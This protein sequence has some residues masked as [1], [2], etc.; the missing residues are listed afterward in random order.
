MPE[1]LSAICSARQGVVA[2]LASHHTEG[3]NAMEMPKPEEH[4]EKL[5]IRVGEWT[6]EETLHPTRGSRTGWQ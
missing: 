1:R 6:G 5:K 4:H 2:H 3:A